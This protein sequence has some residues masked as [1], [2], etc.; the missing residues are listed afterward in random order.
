MVKD[1]ANRS[2]AIRRAS[3]KHSGRDIT[4]SAA[5]SEH[6][7]QMQRSLD[8]KIDVLSR[9][10]TSASVHAC[11]TQTRRL[12]ALLRTFRHALNPSA[13][14]RYEK[15]L[16]RLTHDLS[17]VRNAD[18]E[19]QIIA[20]M[21]KDQGIPDDDGFKLRAIVALAHARAVADL[22]AMM[23]DEAWLRRLGRMRRAASNPALI[24]ESQLPMTEMTARILG[25]RRRRLRRR[26]RLHQ[27]SPKQLHG[28]RLK[29]KTL[30]YVLECC[31]PHRA[32][33]RAEIKQLRLLQDRLGELH[34]EWMLQ[35]RLGRQPRSVRANIDIGSMIRGHR[36]ELLHNIE[37]HENHLLRIWKD[38]DRRR[39]R[40][41]A[42]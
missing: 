14:A 10:V 36:N 9:G 8:R 29:I 13:M 33:I 11:R 34:D 24:V 27:K 2:P 4:V 6:L 19:Q 20:R 41:T 23:I 32:A 35:S 40:H 39:D 30:R 18:V 15:M 22:L 21:A 1:K 25:R 38:E 28:I 17:S 12:R 31:V 37:K 16:R 5:L 26:L 7:R 3:V 42:A